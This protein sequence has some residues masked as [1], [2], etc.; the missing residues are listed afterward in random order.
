MKRKRKAKGAP[1]LK[2]KRPG[3][4]FRCKLGWDINF[5]RCKIKIWPRYWFIFSLS[6]VFDLMGQ[7]KGARDV[8]PW[9]EV[10]G[11]WVNAIFLNGFW[12]A[13][14]VI[15]PYKDAFNTNIVTRAW[16]TK[17]CTSRSNFILPLRNLQKSISQPNLRPLAESTSGPSLLS[18]SR[19]SLQVG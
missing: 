1:G 14:H 7:C 2:K 18:Q 5:W 12:T 19:R 13:H 10:W 11:G 17:P 8:A 15:L 3:V 16:N 9:P 4:D 6:F